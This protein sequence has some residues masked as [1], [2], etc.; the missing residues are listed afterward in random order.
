ME[1]RSSDQFYDHL[2]YQISKLNTEPKKE[3]LIM[4]NYTSYK[5]EF[6]NTLN[7]DDRGDYS[8]FV[9]YDESKIVRDHN[10][11]KKIYDRAFC[12]KRICHFSIFRNGLVEFDG[13][14]S[15]VY[16]MYELQCILDLAKLEKFV[17][18]A[19]DTASVGRLFH[20]DG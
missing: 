9:I 20:R 13:L 8:H 16:S 15:R 12:H 3:L 18:P 10:Y 1:F 7:D 11:M 19:A 4:K 17:D 14:E 6:I 5:V 2:M